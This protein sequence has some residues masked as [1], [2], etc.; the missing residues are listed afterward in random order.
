MNYM[1]TGLQ[2]VLA[3]DDDEETLRNEIAYYRAMLADCSR[4]PHNAGR[5]LTPAELCQRL[6]QSEQ[7]LAT[8]RK[9]RNAR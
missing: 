7:R 2:G 8:L 6:Q 1:V 4:N 3:S 5:H 9:D